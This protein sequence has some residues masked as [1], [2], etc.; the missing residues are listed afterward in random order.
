MST[1]EKGHLFILCIDRNFVF[2][3]LYQ[4]EVTNAIATQ[5]LEDVYVNCDVD[6][7]DGV[8]A[9]IRVPARQL[10]PHAP[11]SCYVAISRTTPFPEGDCTN[12]LHFKVRELDSAGEPIE[13]DVFEDEYELNDLK[14]R[15]TDISVPR[16][17]TTGFR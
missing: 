1:D 3:I 12:A 4:Y 6:A 17:I 5:I 8:Q 13:G 2:F 9:D 7:I 10:W 11:E 16:P 14:L 15:A